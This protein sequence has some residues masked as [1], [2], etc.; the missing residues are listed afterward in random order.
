[1]QD[2]D[3]AGGSQPP[4]PWGPRRSYFAAAGRPHEGQNFHPNS[5]SA[6]HA[7]QFKVV[8][9]WPQ[10]GQNVIGRPVG[11]GS[12]PERHRSPAW[13]TTARPPPLVFVVVVGVGIGAGV[14]FGVAAAARGAEAVATGAGGA[15][16]GADAAGGGGGA[17][18]GAAGLCFGRSAAPA[19]V[20]G[21]G[22]VGED[23][24]LDTAGGG[25]A[26][27]G[28]VLSSS[29]MSRLRSALGESATIDCAN[30]LNAD[31]SGFTCASAAASVSRSWSSTIR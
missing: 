18:G 4:K 2:C 23:T 11:S 10:C 1:E 15:G 8:T 13:G 16:G 5:S 12:L 7:G 24:A 28:F 29:P 14:A 17:A 6:P 30:C 3:T 26:G 27:A 22:G 21:G 9:F 31:G 19:R 20:G 25:L